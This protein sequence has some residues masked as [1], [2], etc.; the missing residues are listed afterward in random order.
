MVNWLELIEEKEDQILA[1]GEK[2][3]KEAINNPHLRYIVEIDEN[4]DVYSWYDVAGG[5][6]FHVSTFEGKSK[7]L[8]EL[9]FQFLDIEISSDALESKLIEKGYKKELEELAQLASENQTSI[10]VEIINGDNDIYVWDNKEF[11][12][13]KPDSLIDIVSVKPLYKKATKRTETGINY[14]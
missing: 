13:L 4:G 7:E 14:I 6:S 1:E 9:C 5:N 12:A 10:E 11:G 8:F 2:A 3:Y